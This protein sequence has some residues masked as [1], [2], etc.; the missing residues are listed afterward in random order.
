MATFPIPF[1][2]TQ[3]YRGGLGFGASRRVKGVKRAHGACD[4]IA[5]KGTEIRAVE[6]GIVLQSPQRFYHGTFAF[7]VQH[8]SFIVRYCEIERD[9]S[10]GIHPGA[11]VYEGQ[12]IAHVGKMFHSSMLHLEIYKGTAKG[13]FTNRT[14]QK[15]LYVKNA[16]YQRRKDLVDPTPYLDEWA[17]QQCFWRE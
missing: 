17:M 4:L 15:Y 7:A 16:N 2:P 11:A 14:N 3:G 5:P 13:G 12:I 8:S 6:D 1:V 10:G 9:L